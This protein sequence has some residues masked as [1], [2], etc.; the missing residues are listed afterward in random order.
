MAIKTVVLGK[1]GGGVE[2]WLFQPSAGTRYR[3]P[4]GDY[5][6]LVARAD[7]SSG[8]VGLMP[9]V[10]A[11]YSA[12]GDFVISRTGVEWVEFAGSIWRVAIFPGRVAG[13]TPATE[14]APTQ[15]VPP[16][17]NSRGEFELGV[18]YKVGDVVEVTKQVSSANGVYECITEHTSSVYDYPWNSYRWRKIS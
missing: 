4:K 17:R 5:T 18:L 8:N 11:H 14:S 9:S 2:G 1:M 15:P 16:N 3:L 12:S 13:R 7:S 10:G 6:F